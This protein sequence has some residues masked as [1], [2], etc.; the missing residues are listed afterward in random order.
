MKKILPLLLLFIAL[1]AGAAETQ[2]DPVPCGI[3]GQWLSYR[4]GEPHPADPVALFN[5]LARTQVVLLGEIHECPEDHRWQ[6]HTLAQLHARRPENTVVALE[7]LPRRLQPVLDRWVSGNL[8]EAELIKQAE[9]DKVW[10]FDPRLYMPLFHYARMNRVPMLALNVEWSLVTAIGDKGWDGVP[11]ALRQG[12][13]RPAEPPPAYVEDLRHEFGLH[14]KKK[15]DEDTFARFVE[16]QTVWDRAMAEVI[17]G[18]LKQH[19]EALVVGIMGQGHVRYGH[20]V[21]HQ[22]DALGV[23]RVAGMM[24]WDGGDGCESIPTDLA[25]AF[26]VVDRP[27]IASPVRL[28]VTLDMSSEDEVHVFHVEP[29]GLAEAGG[30]QEN[31]VLLEVAG[32]PAHNLID[33]RTAV[34]RQA[35]GTWLPFKV[36]RDNVVLD[37][38]IRF[39]PD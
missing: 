24:T 14:L 28:G 5:R 37:V 27:F 2:P 23:S 6:L 7:M 3:R 4:G 29:H 39:P 34:L 21:A 30:M 25:D 32:H 36:R 9:W 31:D 15:K 16:A 11:E 1:A 18:H 35:P 13:S 8:T 17:A 19:P 33:V 38:V 22:L 10:D 12:V 26:Y 20:G